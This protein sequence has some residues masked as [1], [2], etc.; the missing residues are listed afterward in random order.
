MDKDG[1]E[2]MKRGGEATR[3]RASAGEMPLLNHPL[4]GAGCGDLRYMKKEGGKARSKEEECDR[5]NSG[6]P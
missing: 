6:R 1:R 3:T 4:G 2:R 5:I